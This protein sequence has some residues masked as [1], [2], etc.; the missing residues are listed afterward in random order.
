MINLKPAH[1]LAVHLARKSGSMLL[2]HLYDYKIA[3]KKGFNDYCTNMDLASEKMIMQGI[4]E[5]YPDHNILSE[6]KGNLNKKSDYLWI[7]DPIDGTK[8]FMKNLPLWAVSIA[9]Q[10]KEEIVLGVIFNPS[11]HHLY[12]SYK[13]GGAFLNNSN[14]KV[15]TINKLE[16]AVIVVDLANID[17]LSK[18]EVKHVLRR[19]DTLAEKAHRVR[20][21]GVS[22]L[23]MCYVAQGA[24][25]AYIDLV[26]TTKYWD[27]AAGSNIIEEARGHVFDL[28]G[29]RIA[30][31]T[32]HYIATNSRLKKIILNILQE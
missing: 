6:E 2:K 1:T 29:Q 21:L 32:K 3:K 11:T 15:S 26:S 13:G 31:D 16:H 12:S 25:D 14:I 24:Y 17:K 8:N 30:K 18:P 5:K 20:A 22:S 19:L 23:G 27:I 4:L 10:Y 28:Q 9:L 7:I